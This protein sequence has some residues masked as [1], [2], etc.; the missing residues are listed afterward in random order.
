MTAYCISNV[1]PWINCLSHHDVFGCQPSVFTF[2]IHVSFVSHCRS[3]YS[4]HCA[5]WMRLY[6]MHETPKEM[7]WW[8]GRG[9]LRVFHCKPVVCRISPSPFTLLVRARWRIRPF[10]ATKVSVI[11]RL[12]TVWGIGPEPTSL[13]GL[14]G[15]I[16]EQP[17]PRRFCLKRLSE[18]RLPRF[19]IRVF[20]LL[21]YSRSAVPYSVIF[22]T[23]SK[24]SRER[25]PPS[26][27][28]RTRPYAVVLSARRLSY[29]LTIIPLV[30]VTCLAN[31]LCNFGCDLVIK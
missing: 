7:Q 14:D 16:S 25:L 6:Y 11:D 9:L 24:S 8:R 31:Y 4:A 20:L 17:S 12:F 3:S 5:Y 30:F 22:G 23:I 10:F 2:H 27:T 18:D 13:R 29:L 28:Q 1:Y 15:L 19:G 26:T 21:R